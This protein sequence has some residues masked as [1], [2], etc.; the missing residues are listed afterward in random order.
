MFVRSYLPITHKRVHSSFH[1]SVLLLS[2]GIISSLRFICIL[3]CAN[4]SQCLL[5]SICVEQQLISTGSI[6][7][8]EGSVSIL[9]RG[10]H[11]FP[12]KFQLP[13][14]SLPPSFEAKPCQIRYYVKVTLD[15]PYASPPQGMKYF[16]I[17]GPHID[18]MD[19]QYLVSTF[20]HSS[21]H[22]VCLRNR[23]MNSQNRR[24][25][26]LHL[27]LSLSLIELQSLT[28]IKLL[29]SF[30]SLVLTILNPNCNAETVSWSR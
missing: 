20:G 16:T 29:Y 12:F 26:V 30:F 1:L 13:E 2:S 8:S 3:S 21:T 6:E 23:S 27:E 10:Q 7:K 19:E 17:V 22:G 11:S 4:S 25:F 15:I 5:Y 24:L 14:T 28:G 18:C 9:T